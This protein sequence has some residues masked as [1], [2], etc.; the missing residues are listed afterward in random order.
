[1]L[2]P[3]SPKSGG[4]ATKSVCEVCGLRTI[5]VTRVVPIPL[6]YPRAEYEAAQRHAVPAKCEPWE[7]TSVWD[8]ATRNQAH[9]RSPVVRV[10]PCD[11]GCAAQEYIAREDVPGRFGQH[12]RVSRSQRG[13]ERTP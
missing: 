1:M 5:T 11:N 2:P 9:R 3:L 12:A 13:L 10:L 8:Q 7:T 4:I 6:V